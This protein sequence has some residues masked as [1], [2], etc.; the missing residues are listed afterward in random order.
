MF[1]STAYKPIIAIAVSLATLVFASSAASNEAPDAQRVRIM[2]ANTT[3]GPFQAYED[4]GIRIFQG[5]AP[6]I[7]LVQEFNYRDGSLRDLVDT[8]FG[9]AYE[10]HVEGGDEQI[11]NGI[12]SRFPIIESGEWEDTL[13]SNRDYAWARIDI[14]G[15]IDLWAVSLH[16]LTD[17]SRRVPEANEL[18]AYIADRVPDD[19][20]LVIGG[21]F[22]TDTR[23]ESSLGIL[24]AVVDVDG[25]YPEDNAG[26]PDTNAS[27]SKPYDALYADDALD[28]LEIPVQ[29]A[30]QAFDT[31]LVFDSRV[32]TPLADVAPIDLGD[33]GAEQ[34][35]HMAVVRDFGFGDDE[36]PPICAARTT[37][38]SMPG[39]AEFIELIYQFRN[40]VLEP[41]DEGRALISSYYK[42]SD[43]AAA[44]IAADWRLR[45]SAVIL[46]Y[47]V[48]PLL[49][50]AVATGE[51]HLN[52]QAAGQI[53][54]FARALAADASPELRAEID[55]FIAGYLD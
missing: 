11:P 35:Q 52:E 51:L 34:M 54:T 45:I 42:H 15:S 44:I 43:E 28:A 49:E 41:T 50:E 32:Y 14:P 30:D 37:L 17:D 23:G 55:R 27:R 29:I 12:I 7:V 31:G 46:T 47:R 13:V 4:P 38:A 36:E 9:A 40:R 10:F 53:A 26:D 48:R 21:D 3:S 22:N 16:W 18:V 39:A 24:G 33:S 8:A 5:L 2:A 6:D 25:P 19:V 20:Y 1:K